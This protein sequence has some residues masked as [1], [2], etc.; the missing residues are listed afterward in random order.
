M[1]LLISLVNKIVSFLKI[2]PRFILKRTDAEN[3][4][5]AKFMEFAAAEI[6]PSDRILDA[7]AGSCP[8]KHLFSHAKYE[9]T[10][11]ADIFNKSFKESHD[12]ICD[13]CNISKPDNSY[14][15]IICTQVLDHIE[16]PQKAINEFFRVLKPDGKLFLTAPQGWGLHGEPYHFFNF[17]KWGLQSL[18]Q[19]ARFKIIFIKPRGGML[20]YLGKRIKTLPSYIINQYLFQKN[21]DGSRKFKPK[22]I[23]VILYPLYIIAIPFCCFLIPLLFFYLDKLDKKQSYPLGYACYRV[24]I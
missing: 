12:F 6:K 22:L 13:L 1:E 19:K 24:K 2:L 9:S 21:E 7:G 10:D 5:I 11:F 18:F 20:W 8:Y 4:G 23:T 3:F 16:E 17:T 15:V 14:D